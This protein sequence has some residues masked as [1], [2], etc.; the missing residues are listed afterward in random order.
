MRAN[1]GSK[2]VLFEMPAG[3]GPDGKPI[4]GWFNVEVFEPGQDPRETSG[5]LCMTYTHKVSARLYQKIAARTDLTHGR[6][7]KAV[8]KATR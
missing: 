6:I 3:S 1:D 5:A 2:V 8:R 4:E 7:I